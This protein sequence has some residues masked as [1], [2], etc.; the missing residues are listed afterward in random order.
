MSKRLE[1]ELLEVAQWYTAH[2][3]DAMSVESRMQFLTKSID[4]L[5]W[6]FAKAVEDIQHL[7]GRKRNGALMPHDPYIMT[8]VPSNL[9]TA[10]GSYN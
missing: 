5:I 6:A 9:R 2:K 8:A 3:G 10:T 7:E 1:K 4:Y